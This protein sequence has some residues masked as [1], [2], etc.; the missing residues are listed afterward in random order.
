MRRTWLSDSSLKAVAVSSPEITGICLCKGVI[1][2]KGDLRGK[3]AQHCLCC[4]LRHPLFLIQVPIDCCR[5]H[6]DKH[7]AAVPDHKMH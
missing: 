2:S 6:P 7:T 1:N 4:S 3:K 5:R